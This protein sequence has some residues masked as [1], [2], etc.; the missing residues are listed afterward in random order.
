M[1]HSTANR[2]NRAGHVHG[3]SNLMLVALENVRNE[4]HS[5]ICAMDAVTGE[6]RP[7][8]YQVSKTRLQLSQAGMKGCN[9][10][11]AMY[12]YLLPRV[13]T[14]ASVAL[15]SLQRHH[16]EVLRIPSVHIGEWTLDR[17]AADWPSYGEAYRSIRLI[18]TE[19]VSSEKKILYPILRY[20]GSGGVGSG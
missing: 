11:G 7:D 14:N 2:T 4:L 18:M 6:L 19:Y 3:A 5:A 9:A 12:E 13:G 15:Q 17:I 8:R 16:L 10:W 20:E 1:V